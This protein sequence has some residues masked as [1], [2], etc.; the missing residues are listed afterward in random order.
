L[1]TGTT[2][3]DTGTTTSTPRVWCCPAR[4]AARRL[5]RRRGYNTYG[6]ACRSSPLVAASVSKSGAAGSVSGGGSG[7][8]RW[9]LAALSCVCPVVS[10]M[11]SKADGGK[12]SAP[13]LDDSIMSW[14]LSMD[15]GKF[16]FP[17]Q[18]YNREV[19]SHVLSFTS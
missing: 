10:W 9:C 17:A 2:T 12:S 1:Y 18:V 19:P 11:R 3:R 16:W 4:V 8:R 5:S 7:K 6:P 14:Y 15:N 13:V